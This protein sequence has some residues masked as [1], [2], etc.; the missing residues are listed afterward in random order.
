VQ[1]IIINKL[2]NKPTLILWELHVAKD[3]CHIQVNSKFQTIILT[4]LI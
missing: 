1:T 4:I 3:K 2:I